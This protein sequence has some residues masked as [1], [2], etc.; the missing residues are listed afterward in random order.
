MALKEW[1]LKIG[2]VRLEAENEHKCHLA[3]SFCL[4]PNRHIVL[5]SAQ[6]FNTTLFLPFTH[7]LSHPPILP[8]FSAGNRS[9]LFEIQVNSC[10]EGPRTLM[11]NEP[12]MWLLSPG[13]WDA[14]KVLWQTGWELC[15]PLHW[16]WRAHHYYNFGLQFSPERSIKFANGSKLCLMKDGIN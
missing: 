8:S 9:F 3:F 7:Q 4:E 12:L 2:M 5:L 10:P 13:L 11:S 1:E 6:R 16:V 14:C 15:W